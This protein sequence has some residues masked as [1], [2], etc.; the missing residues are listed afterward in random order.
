MRTLD[1]PEILVHCLYY[2][3]FVVNPHRSINIYDFPEVLN[4]CV[5]INKKFS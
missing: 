3:K 2:V 5:N 1:L 4:E